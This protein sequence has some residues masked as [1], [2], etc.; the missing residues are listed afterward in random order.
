MIDVILLVRFSILLLIH[1]LQMNL[2]WCVLPVL[3]C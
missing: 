3:N 2:H 1:F